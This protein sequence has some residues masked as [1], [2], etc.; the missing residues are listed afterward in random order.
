V[1][2]WVTSPLQSVTD[3]PPS[4]V[5]PGHT[6]DDRHA[7]DVTPAIRP[8]QARYLITADDAATA[9]TARAVSSRRHHT[10]SQTQPIGHQNS[11][12]CP[13]GTA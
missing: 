2:E 8:D 11:A 4:V 13:G 1:T 3:P 5:M 6:G 12:I 9:H 10:S 7:A